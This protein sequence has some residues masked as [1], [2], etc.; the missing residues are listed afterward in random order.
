MLVCELGKSK[1]AQLFR[2]IRTDPTDAQSDIVMPAMLVGRF[3][4]HSLVARTRRLVCGMHPSLH[5]RLRSQLSLPQS[6]DVLVC[7]Y[8]A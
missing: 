4:S 7:D 1:Q 2:Y 3:S 5:L 8:F 6:Q